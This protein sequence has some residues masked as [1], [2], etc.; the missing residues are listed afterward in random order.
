MLTAAVA[1]AYIEGLQGEGVAACVKHFVGNDTEFERMTI[2]VGDRRADP[3]RAVPRAVRGGRAARRRAAVMTGYNRLNGT[4]C[5]EHRVAAGRTCCA[6][7]GASTALVMSDWF[8][9]HS[10][11]DLAAAP[12]STSRCPARRA[13]VASTCSTPSTPARSQRP[14]ST[15]PSARLLA[16]AEWT[17]AADAGTAEVTADDPRHAR[18]SSGAPRRGRMVLL[19]NE[20]GLLPLAS[21][22][23]GWRSIG[24][25]ARFG[26]P[27][28]GGSARVHPDHGRGPLDALQARGLDVTFEPGGSIAKYL[29]TVRGDFELA[30]QRRRRRQRRRCRPNRLSWYWD[31]PPADG[32]AATG[33]AARHQ[34]ARSVPDATGD[35]EFGVRAVGPVD[36]LGRRRRRSSSSTGRSAAAPSSAWAARR[37]AGTVDAGGGPALPLDVDYPAHGDELVR[38]LV[39]GAA[40]V[41]DG[42]HIARAAAVGRRRRRRH[43]RSS[44]PTTTGRP[45]ARTARRWTCRGDQDALVAAV[46][47]ANPNTVVVLNTGSPV[48]MPWLADV[49]AVLQLWFPGQEIGDALVDVLTGDAEPG[50]RLPVT[51][52]AR[53]EDTPAFA[54]YPG[55]DGRAV[56]A[57]GLFIGHRWYDREGIEP[58]FPFGHGLGY[59]T[60]ALR[61]GGVDRR[62]EDGVTV[63]VDVRQHRRR[64]GGEVVQVYVQPPAGDPDR[65]L[66]HLAG[67]AP[68]RPRRRRAATTVAVDARPPGLRLV[69]RRR[70]DRPAR[71]LHDPRRPLVRDLQVA[72]TVRP[73]PNLGGILTTTDLGGIR[74]SAGEDPAR[75]RNGRQRRQ[76]IGSSPAAVSAALVR[77]NGREPKNPLWADRGD[78]WAD[79][80]TTW[81]DVSMSAFLRRAWLPQRM[82]TTGCV[83]GVDGADDLVGERLPAVALVRRGLP[84]P[85]GE[86]RVEQQHALHGPRLEVAVARR[87]DARGRSPAPCG[88]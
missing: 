69:A 24:P 81:R 58:L 50:G 27:Q 75:I 4:Y 11:A 40:P 33:F 86:R 48:T 38:G 87:R 10:A 56:Y 21:T 37:C 52:P 55:T 7:S 31:K 43:R 63:D 22:H 30:V 66:R 15:A 61:P 25:Y 74:P 17:G 47:A 6:A 35:W 82:N 51:F 70:V 45:R 67:F 64:A 39:V 28:G 46:V 2:D 8:G 13:S 34:S 53:L 65:P 20:G 36:R 16:L 77:E 42:D 12:G 26:R 72:G 29:P 84:G 5:S 85:H 14:I 49:P 32:L 1:V 73:D 79:S 57:E 68:R 62:A 23:R 44:A 19:K 60:F 80:M 18:A 83:L 71:R 88:C 3:A 78:G 59:T 76:S 41:P 54:T 9:T